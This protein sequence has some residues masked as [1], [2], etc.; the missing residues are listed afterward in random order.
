MR[1]VIRKFKRFLVDEPADLEEYNE[2]INDPFC[3]ITDRDIQLEET[4]HY[5]DEGQLARKEKRTTMLVHWEE[6]QL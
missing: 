3:H 1:K 6:R 5:N 4:S 2:I